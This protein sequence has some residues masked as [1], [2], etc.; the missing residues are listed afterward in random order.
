MMERNTMSDIA[1]GPPR[2]HTIGIG[3][4]PSN[5]SLA[6]LFESVSD[7]RI[8]LFDAAAGPAWHPSL[9]FPGVRMQ[10]GWLKDLVSA[11][12]PRH[13]LTFLNY[14]VT[15]GRLYGL[16]NA[17]FDAIPRIEYQRYLCWAAEQI[18]HISYGV[19]VD[20]ISFT[21]TAF[22]VFSGG[23]TLAESEHL[24]LGVGTRPYI[25]VG[26]EGLPPHVVFIA[27]EL[28]ERIDAMQVDTEAPVGVVGA[29]QTGL[30]CVLRLL[31]NGF[32][33][34]RWFGRH[35]WFQGIDDSP[36][37]NDFYRPSHVKHLKELSRATR[38]TH[39]DDHKLTGD[40][41]TPGGLRVLYQANY[42]AML[43]LGRFPVTLLPY[44]DVIG[45]EVAG[46]DVILRCA[47]PERQEEYPLRHIV[48]AAGRRAVPMPFDDD[49]RERIEVDEDNELMLE[50]DYSVRW[51]GMNGHKIF[52][53]NH[54]RYSHGLTNAGLTLLPVRSAAVLNSLFGRTFF[55]VRDE[56][57]S[58]RW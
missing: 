13:K 7:E 45:A 18:S 23:R 30:E 34:I 10:T 5:L 26:L 16:I 36:M 11:A 54:S 39:I 2:F 29:G 47:A 24:V 37:A 46:P 44:R 9:L 40:A 28:G 25:P 19:R 53:F 14:L 6:A 51:K 31:G 52:A 35:Q 32:T 38:R 8:A 58:V 21:G 43:E 12:D 33:D 20:R 42:D 41:L 1:S 3:A 56:L 49:L 57:C 50:P 4:G 22:E 17:Q 48:V 55:E 15:T 27:D